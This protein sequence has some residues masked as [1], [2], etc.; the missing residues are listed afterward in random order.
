MF[1]FSPSLRIK[2]RL[3][4][5]L[6]DTAFGILFFSSFSIQR[7]YSANF[8]GRNRQVAWIS[9]CESV[10]SFPHFSVFLAR[11]LFFPRSCYD[12]TVF[13]GERGCGVRFP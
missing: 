12:E 5:Y 1:D 13:F 10:C 11:L 9:P 3:Q 4:R 2:N 7:K 6:S 8:V